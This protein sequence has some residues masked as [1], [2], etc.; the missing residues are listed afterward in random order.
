M[1]IVGLIMLGALNAEAGPPGIERANRE[2]ASAIL[3]SIDTP[4]GLDSSMR[5][6]VQSILN[7]RV[8]VIGYVAPQGA[9]AASAGTFI[10]HSKL[11]Q[12]KAGPRN[13]KKAYTVMPAADTTST[14]RSTRGLSVT[15]ARASTSGNVAKA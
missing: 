15:D 11:N 2:R 3:L 12:G 13:D 5:T 8:P 7:S 9:R 10:L 4:G 6:I 14:A 1:A